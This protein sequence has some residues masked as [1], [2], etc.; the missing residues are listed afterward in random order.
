MGLF[1]GGEAERL[2]RQEPV[3]ASSDDEIMTAFLCDCAYADTEESCL[4]PDERAVLRDG[5]VQREKLQ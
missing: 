5:E 2:H 3:A 1:Y 4:K